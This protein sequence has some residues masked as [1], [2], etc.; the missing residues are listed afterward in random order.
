MNSSYF[1]T[2]V[3]LLGFVTLMIRVS[4]FYLYSYIKIPNRVKRSLG[5]IPVA[6]LPA[7]VAPAAFMH[8]GDVV[9]LGGHERVLALFMALF[10]SYRTKNVFATIFSG[11][12]FLYLIRLIA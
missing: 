5:F 2:T 8:Q 10:V 1:W 12:V 6:V 4:F 11:I 9:S 3:F 7:L